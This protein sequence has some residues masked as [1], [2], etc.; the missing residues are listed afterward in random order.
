MGPGWKGLQEA[1]GSSNVPHINERATSF[2][3]LR[4]RCQSQDSV[5]QKDCPLC[6]I[7]ILFYKITNLLHFMIWLANGIFNL[8]LY[9]FTLNLVSFLKENGEINTSS[10]VNYTHQLKCG[11]IGVLPNR[12]AHIRARVSGDN[13][14]ADINCWCNLFLSQNSSRRMTKRMNLFVKVCHGR[15]H[16]IL[17]KEYFGTFP[18]LLRGKMICYKL[19]C[20]LTIGVS[21][22][23]LLT[24]L[25][26]EIKVFHAKQTFYYIIN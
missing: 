12:H 1:N 24:R 26:H 7:S 9:H 20:L 25:I 2:I 21:Q 3:T 16:D 17:P 4:T 22:I 5:I 13:L 11:N 19:R 6:H 18:D 23:L 10:Q 14:S 15:F 8:K